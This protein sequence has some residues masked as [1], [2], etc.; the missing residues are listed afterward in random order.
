MPHSRVLEAILSD[1]RDMPEADAV[2]FFGFVQRGVGHKNSD[3]DFYVVTSG[4]EYWRAG[5]LVDGVQVELFFNPAPKMWER[6]EQGDAVAIH[7]LATGDLLLDR[8]GVG[9]R[10][11][12]A[13]RRLWKEGPRPLSAWEQAAWRYRLT[14]LAQDIEDVPG[15]APEARMLAGLLVP[16]ALE[17]FCERNCVWC[18]KPKRLIGRIRDLD[19]ELGDPGGAV[20][21]GRHG[22]NPGRCHR[23]SGACA[24]RR[25]NRRLREQ[26]G[27]NRPLGI[28]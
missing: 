16:K 15:G 2:V 20:V 4:H 19:R 25:P 17:A 22:P 23:R 5:R 6:L 24:L 10:L 21:R 18:D 8:S 28:P 12:A 26:S 11:S 27:H 13:A 3:F 9:A 14:D 1:L 7:A